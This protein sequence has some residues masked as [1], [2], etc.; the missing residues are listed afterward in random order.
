MTGFLRNYVFTSYAPWNSCHSALRGFNRNLD[1]VQ[2]LKLRNPLYE[3]LVFTRRLLYSGVWHRAGRSEIINIS[4]E[5]SISIFG[6]KEWPEGAVR[7]HTYDSLKFFLIFTWWCEGFYSLRN[8]HTGIPFIFLFNLC[9]FIA[10]MCWGYKIQWE[11]VICEWQTR[12]GCGIKSKSGFTGRQ[13]QLNLYQFYC[14]L[15]VSAS[16]KGHHHAIKF[17]QRKIIRYSPL[18]WYFFQMT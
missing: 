7:N 10:V 8:G 2:S 6:I 5:P 17:T 9:Y 18:K 3:K 14:L 4:L 11:M 12:K 1:E 15:R 13:P 16:V